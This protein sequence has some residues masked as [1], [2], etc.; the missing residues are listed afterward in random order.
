M[1]CILHSMEFDD[2]PDEARR[3]EQARRAR[4]FKTAKDAAEYF[5]WNYETYAQHENGTRGLTRAVERYAKAYRVDASWILFGTGQGPSEGVPLKGYIGAGQVVQPLD[6][7]DDETVE[8]PADQKPGTVAA[9]VKGDSMLP[10]FRE[11]WIVYWSR[12]LPPH[13]MINQLCVVQLENGEIYI[14]VLRPGSQPGLWTLQSV[15]ATVRDIE[16]QVVSW[17]APIDWIRVR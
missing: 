4:G 6:D 9:I 14:K 1:P 12:Q 10:A 5:G 8:A 16:D 15:N 7:I 11:G 2:R 3:L 17:V 13:E